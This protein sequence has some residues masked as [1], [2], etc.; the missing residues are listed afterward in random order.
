MGAQ[1]DAITDQG[2]P[3]LFQI[4]NSVALNSRAFNRYLTDLLRPKTVAYMGETTEFNKTVLE[5]LRTSLKAANIELVNVST[6]DADT[7]DFTSII[8]K[9]K[10]LNPD[11]LY[12]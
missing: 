2:S 7:N 5:H 8:T 12:V 1:S 11:L 3:Y 4:N 10:S 9:I 6:Y